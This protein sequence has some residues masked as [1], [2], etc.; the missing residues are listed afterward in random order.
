MAFTH[1]TTLSLQA[2]AALVN[3]REPETLATMEQLDELCSRWQ[4]SGSRTHDDPEL[5]L[6]RNVRN[7]LA[8]FWGVDEAAVVSL[9]NDLL[10]E[11]QALPQ[12]LRHDDFDWHIHAT[13]A[14]APLAVRM[15]VE[16]AMAMI[17]VVR[18]GELD[19]LSYCAADDCDD[20]VIDLSRNRSRKF[21]DSGCGN[22]ANVAAYR[23][24]RRG[25]DSLAT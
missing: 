9:I 10:A 3:T 17:D 14:E 22:R 13:P 7:R 20:V 23:A 2:L 11:G 18:A 21:C 12:L 24:R 5:Q 25:L 19:R 16:Y 6:V 8:G 15:T 1:D 4:W